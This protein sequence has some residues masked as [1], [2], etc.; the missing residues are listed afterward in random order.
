M[1]QVTEL[2]QDERSALIVRQPGEIADQLAQLCALLHLVGEPVEARLD[3]LE[4]HARL[5]PR[6]EH[7]EAA[8]AR[9]REEPGPH[10]IREAT[11]G[12]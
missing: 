12:Q 7:G 5:A 11:V 9:D 4:R 1:A 3:V 2:G 8:V 10:G 6:G